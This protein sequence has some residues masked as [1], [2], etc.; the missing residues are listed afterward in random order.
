MKKILFMI[1][2]LFCGLLSQEPAKAENYN[3][4]KAENFKI[5]IS[6]RFPVGSHRNEVEAF[7]KERGVEYSY[8]KR[9]NK[10]Y[11]ILPKIGRYRLI[12]QT[13]LLIRIQFNDHEDLQK[14]EFEYEHTG[15]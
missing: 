4:K 10:I 6:Q 15:L 14:L 5:E 2:F 3:M 11:A 9:E 13:S 7:L 12:Y 1:V 8:V